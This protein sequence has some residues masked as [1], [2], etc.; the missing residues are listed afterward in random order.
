MHGPLDD[1]QW[2][3]IAEASLLKPMGEEHGTSPTPEEEAALLGEE[4]EPPQV[5][6]SL[7]EQLEIPRVVEP[8]E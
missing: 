2:D 6:A 7:P 5:P 8:A 1:P 4:I 3:D